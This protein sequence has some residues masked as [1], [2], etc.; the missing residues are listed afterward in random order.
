VTIAIGIHASDGIVIAA[1]T[2]VSTGDY[3]K[4]MKGKIACFYAQDGD[5]TE[6]CIISGAGDSGYVEALTHK[7]GETFQT[8]DPKAQVNHV[9]RGGPSLQSAF[10]DC[11]KN[12]YKEH[13]IPFAAYPERKRPDVE[14]LIACQRKT[15]KGMFA[16]EK[17]VLNYVSPYRAVGMGSTFAELF[18]GKLWCGMCVEQAEIL[19]AYVV[20][21]TKESVENCGKF[22]TIATMRNSKIEET[23]SGGRLLPTGAADFVDDG[24]IDAWEQSF[25]GKWGKA[26]REKIFSMIDEEISTPSTAR[27]SKGRR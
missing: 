4:G 13:I 24:K 2:Q 19:A 27:K 5:W 22:T 14:M 3:M 9:A 6:S 1:D 20:Y 21:L 17:T 23:P 10:R 11:I 12:F 8:L 25:R 7:L 18:L 16:S 26:E 15:I